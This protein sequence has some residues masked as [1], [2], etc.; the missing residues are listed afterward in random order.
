MRRNVDIWIEPDLTEVG[1]VQA[2]SSRMVNVR[3]EPVGMGV[4]SVD[5]RKV[6]VYFN[7]TEPFDWDSVRN[8]PNF[9]LV[10]FS[11]D[12]DDLDNTPELAEV[13]RTGDYN[14]LHN[15]PNI[16]AVPTK[17]SDLEN[18]SGFVT[19]ETVGLTHYYRKERLYTREEVDALVT[20]FDTAHYEVVD[21]LPEPSENTMGTIYLVNGE[22][23][24]KYRFVSSE[25]N[26]VY[27]WI[28][29]GPIDINLADYV[30]RSQFNAA[31]ENRPVHRKATESEIEQ[32]V[33]EHTWEQGVVYFSVE[34]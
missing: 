28:D 27:T 12:Y 25:H 29:L 32:M 8:K 26:G 13:A 1:V 7:V 19:T 15:K 20:A 16:P 34:G 4:S 22:D 14:D 3:L 11:G 31:M 10:A 5:G 30:T 21:E 6:T 23:D 9:A 18:D 2:E 33:D 24:K 17:T